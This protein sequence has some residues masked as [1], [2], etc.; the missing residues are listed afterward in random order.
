M[1]RLSI[2]P[3]G[4]PLVLIRLVGEVVL[5]LRHRCLYLSSKYFQVQAVA[6]FVV[7]SYHGYT[8]W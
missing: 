2:E 1:N 7:Y 6:I 4:A 5:S 8:V 3:G